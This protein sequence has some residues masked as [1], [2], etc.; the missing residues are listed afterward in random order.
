MAARITPLV[1]ILLAV[2]A[3]ASAQERGL[4]GHWNFTPETVQD[5]RVTNFVDGEEAAVTGDPRVVQHDGRGFLVLASR[6]ERVVVGRDLSHP[7]LPR[8]AFTAE[9]W[10]SV[11]RAQ[12]W[13][14]IVGAIQD[15]GGF[16]KGWLL[17][18]SGASF[19]LAVSSEGAND[20]DGALTYMKGTTSFELGRWYHVLGTYEGETMRLFVNG[21]E[22]ATSSA[23]SGAILYPDHAVYEIGGYHDDDEDFPLLGLLG[24]V[25]VWKRALSADEVAERFADYAWYEAPSAEASPHVQLWDFADIVT[26]GEH[27]EVG[28]PERA[29]E[30]PLATYDREAFTLSAVLQLDDVHARGALLGVRGVD[31]RPDWVLGT[32]GSQLRFGVL[33]AGGIEE[34]H[35]ATTRIDP[36]SFEW[37][38]VLVTYDGGLQRIYVNGTLAGSCRG[39]FGPTGAADAKTIVVGGLGEALDLRP[40]AGRLRE[41]R[42]HDGALSDE[43]AREA[44]RLDPELV[45]AELDLDVGPIVQLQGVDRASIHLPGTGYPAN[46]IE[47][48]GQGEAPRRI[49]TEA[50]MIPEV[51]GLDSH[52]LYR[53]RILTV[54]ED[55]RERASSTQ[56]LDTA[57]NY[58]DPPI[59][60]RPVPFLDDERRRLCETTA[61]N[62]RWPWQGYCVLLG[63]SDGQM[64]Y[65]LAKR[66]KLTIIAV[67]DDAQAVQRA[68]EVLSEAGVYGWRVSIHHGPLDDL[69]FGDHFATVV[70]VDPE[71]TFRELENAG[72][73]LRRILHP[74]DASIHLPIVDDRLL[75]H[76]SLTRLRETLEDGEPESW[77][78][79]I[80]DDGS[81]LKRWKLSSARTSE[82]TH[83]YANPANTTSSEE[84]FDP[85][86]LEV[87]WFGRPGPRPMLDRGSRPPAPLS[88]YGRLYVQGD[89]RLMAL[90]A[91]NGAILWCTE[92]PELRRTNIPR[93]GS[94]MVLAP[95]RLSGDSPL[96]FPS[97]EFLL[98]AVGGRCIPFN[99]GYGTPQM[100]PIAPPLAAR[101]DDGSS[102]EWGFLAATDRMLLGTVT[103]PEA[104]YRGAEGEWYDGLGGETEDVL[105]SALFGF[106]LHEIMGP[107]PHGSWT[108][109]NGLIIHPTIA[110][111]DGVV[112]FVEDRAPHPE[113]VRKGRLVSQTGTDQFL[114]AL[115]LKTGEKRWEKAHDFRKC[116]RV[117]YLSVSDGVIVVTGSADAHYLYGFDAKNGEALWSHRQDFVRDHHGGA[118]QHP[119]ITGGVVYHDMQGIDLRTGE[120]LRTDLPE[121]RGCGTIA[122]SARG[123]FYRHYSHSVWDFATGTATE[124]NGVRSGCWIAMIPA[125]GL[126]LA[127]EAS[128][129]CSCADPIQTSVA[130]RPASSK[131]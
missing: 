53:Y 91:F 49:T 124:W 88:A 73:E 109:H 110:A 59:P 128:S 16:E 55:G 107:G 34:T 104:P 81:W 52:R 38:H 82:W 86:N 32:G 68:R 35:W 96:S 4:V 63:I 36:A 44:S 117:F 22:E 123:L 95:V 40:I 108:Y 130:F 77:K 7:A 62:V 72:K 83:Q 90:D 102:W 8:E 17:G 12:P 74:F 76:P 15:N 75:D 118:M 3:T 24:E 6:D 80:S 103:K 42:L 26:D 100:Q 43:A 64:A 29:L 84:D 10:V 120:V 127:P 125:G 119:V 1:G 51:G 87:Q 78:P 92:F 28:G 56:V 131:E 30:M 41:M 105:G 57:F 94:N 113:S 18:Y 93:D 9:A 116:D 60:E 122:G 66:T 67:E 37:I 27:L 106:R 21:K 61:E 25:R 31:G 98:I 101:P 114:V 19:C 89:R 14:G 11:D 45:R 97:Y 23:Q 5:G 39:A 2:T 13:G 47:I 112:Y 121:R 46:V 58:H 126:L 115:D 69:P 111:D 85:G 65:Q 129:G 70:V 54:D 48:A 79:V 33:R 20:G 50:G 99:V 71:T